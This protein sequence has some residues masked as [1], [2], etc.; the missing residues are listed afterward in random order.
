V[1]ITVAALAPS[2]YSRSGRQLLRR[3][4][5]RFGAPPD[6]YALYG[7]EALDLALDAVDAA[8]PDK[9][10]VIRWLLRSA[11][12]RDSP[13]GRYSINRYGDTTERHEEL[14][15]RADVPHAHRLR[16]GS[17]DRGGDRGRPRGGR[18]R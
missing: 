8:G 11:N 5:G 6:P 14:R 15:T 18:P 13:L 16:T 7:Y 1:F 4:R 9:T 17:L 2:A 12:D 3:Y 10:A